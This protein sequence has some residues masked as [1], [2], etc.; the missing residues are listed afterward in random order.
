MDDLISRAA[1]VRI[2]ADM[3]GLCRNDVLRES[4]QAIK[5]LPAVD[6]MPVVQGEWV[7]EPDRVNHYHCSNCGVVWGVMSKAMKYCPNC[8]AMMTNSP[9]WEVE[10]AT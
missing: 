2:I 10:D 4:I 3:H 6:A 9:M 7:E 5:E 1:A 8:A